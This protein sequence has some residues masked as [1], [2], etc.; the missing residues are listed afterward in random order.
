MLIPE[1]KEKGS[2]AFNQLIHIFTTAPRWLTWRGLLEPMSS[3]QA[4]H[5]HRCR[6]KSDGSSQKP[7]RVFC[8]IL[9]GPLP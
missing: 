5:W 4:N 6:H 7:V 8:A 1:D 3:G 9:H 2:G